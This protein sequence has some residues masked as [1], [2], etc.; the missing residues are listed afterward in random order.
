MHHGT[1][2]PQGLRTIATPDGELSYA[3]AG[4]GPSVLA[5]QGAGVIGHG[6]RPQVDGLSTQFR[7]ITFDNRGIGNNRRGEGALTIERMAGDALAIIDAEGLDRVHVLGHSMGGLIA[8]HLALTQRERVKSLAL[9]CTFADGA[10]A[11][12]LS[13]R[14]LLLALRSRIGTRAMRRTG[15]VR[16]VMPSRYVREHDCAALARDLGDLFGR[17][18]AD[19]PPI[20]S[21]QLRAMSRYTARSRLNEL[22]GIPTLVVSARRDPI[23]GPALGRDIASRIGGARYIEFDAASHALPIQLAD[24][25]NAL[26]SDHL[27]AVESSSAAH[28]HVI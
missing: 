15:M 28:F 14:M 10:R 18:L 16:M 2:M 22:S 27:L 4:A 5:I 25:V 3:V 8:Q 7:F 26:L 24:E 19:Q 20:I 6:W 9:L 23:A 1:E 12:R 21:E 17:D 13:G 11:T